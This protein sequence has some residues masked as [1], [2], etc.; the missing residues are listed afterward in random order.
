M[1]ASLVGSEMCIRDRCTAHLRLPPAFPPCSQRTQ[2]NGMV[3]SSACE[4]KSVPCCG[5]HSSRARGWSTRRTTG[6]H[7]ASDSDC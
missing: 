1:S 2:C 5:V 6:G 7:L 3:S 4:A